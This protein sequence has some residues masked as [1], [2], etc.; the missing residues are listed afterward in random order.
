MLEQM[1]LR[2]GVDLDKLLQATAILASALPEERMRSHVYE[3]G[4]PKVYG[5]AA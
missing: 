5:S 3:A 1:G 4:I 2:T